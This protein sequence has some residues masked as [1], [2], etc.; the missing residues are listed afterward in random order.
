[1][2]TKTKIYAGLAIAALLA[3]TFEAGRYSKPAKV[4]V[5]T[6][7]VIKEVIKQ[8]TTKDINKNKVVVI[9]KTIHPDG[10]V[11]TD[12]T[13]T[14]RGTIDS[15]TTTDIA[16]EAIKTSSTTT[17]RDSGLTIEALALFKVC[18]LNCPPD[19]GV[20]VSKRVFGNLRVGVLG[21]TQKQIGVSVGLDF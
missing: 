14:D 1:M 5:V 11:T 2:E 17:T 19:Y 21:T 18:N 7:E 8:D 9:H 20:A 15:H 10:S 6:K 16:K 4:E 3:L 12:T 13:I